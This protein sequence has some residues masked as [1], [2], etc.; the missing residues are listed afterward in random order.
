MTG[1]FG[2]GPVR[3]VHGTGL[4]TPAQDMELS[5]ATLRDMGLPGAEARLRVHHPQMTAAFSRLDSL[6]P[7]FPAAQDAARARGFA[8]VVRP[9]G[10]RLAAYHRQALVLDLVA[11]H[12][13]SRRHIKERFLTGA[14]ALVGGLRELGVDARVGAVPGEYCPGEFSVNAGGA[15]KLVGTAQRIT[16]HGYLFSAVVLVADPEPVREV[17]RDAYAALEFTW[18]P[19]TVGCVADAVP[20]ATVEAVA[21]VLVPRMVGLLGA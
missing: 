13:E 15:T 6:A 11:P 4:S 20:G 7:G 16:R 8:P 5:T 14:E 9:A 3:V 18:E 10:G 21:A 19:A 17:L 2:D 1:P 12:P